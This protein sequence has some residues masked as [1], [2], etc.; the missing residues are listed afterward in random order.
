MGREHAQQQAV[1]TII[2]SRMVNL[3]SFDAFTAA[4]LQLHAQAPDR[5]RCPLVFPCSAGILLELTLFPV[6]FSR[7]S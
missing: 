5:V 4:A 1:E 2:L 7:F 6:L 3:Q